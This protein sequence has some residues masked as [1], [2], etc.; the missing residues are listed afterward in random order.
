MSRENP[1]NKCSLENY[2]L[3]LYKQRQRQFSYYLLKPLFE[4]TDSTIYINFSIYIIPNTGT[5]VTGSHLT[6]FCMT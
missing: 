4:G 5:Y 1:Y 3:R 2:I 6:A